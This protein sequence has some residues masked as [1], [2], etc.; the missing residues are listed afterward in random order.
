MPN[1]WPLMWNV[2]FVEPWT[3]GHAPVARVYQPA[4]VFGGAWV[5]RPLPVADVPFFRNSAIVGTR[6]CRGVLRDEVLAQA[7][8]GEEDR[9][10]AQRLVCRGRA[11]ARSRLARRPARGRSRQDEQDCGRGQQRDRSKSNE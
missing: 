5:S 8:G 4:P 3:P 2:L 9:L 6:P 1:G 7:V 10:L 11:R